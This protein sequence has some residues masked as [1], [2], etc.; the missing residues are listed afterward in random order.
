MPVRILSVED[1]K[2]LAG[3]EIGVSD[4]FTVTQDRISRFADATEDHQWIHV[5]VARAAKESPYGTTIAHGF[6]S[7]S[8]ISYLTRQVFRVDGI[9]MAVNY[10]LDRVRFPAAVRSGT[11]VRGRVKLLSVED[12]PGGVQIK[13][14]VTL[15]FQD[16][17]KPACVAELLL[18]Y[19][20]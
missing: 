1:L 9:R 18:R 20:M 8:L 14:G 3:Q 12:F 17:S 16:S 19:Y 4:Y 10:G 13:L 7:L 6:L 11:Q 5:D 15:E 2:K